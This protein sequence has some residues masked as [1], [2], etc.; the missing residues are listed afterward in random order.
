MPCSEAQKASLVLD[1][2]RRSDADAQRDPTAAAAPAEYL[3]L[4][5]A[6][7]WLQDDQL[8]LRGLC[9]FL[10]TADRHKVGSARPVAAWW[11]PPCLR[12][13]HEVAPR[14][15]EAAGTRGAPGG[16]AGREPGAHG[17]LLLLLLDQEARGRGRR[18]S[19]RGSEDCQAVGGRRGLRQQVDR[20][21]GPVR[22]PHFPALLL[23]PQAAQ[24]PPEDKAVTPHTSL[25]DP[26]E[27][28]HH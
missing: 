19:C 14:A 28:S 6:N 13:R 24:G 23:T 2:A 27:P 25:D 3:G 7:L 5:D 11:A 1:G 8:Q 17:A 10:D 16:A 18:T 9:G 22:Y 20:R 4:Q 15:S 21:S 26:L 12:L